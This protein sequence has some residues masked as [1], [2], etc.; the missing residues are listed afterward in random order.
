ML[1]RTSDG[2]R[3]DRPGEGWWIRAGSRAGLVVVVVVVIVVVHGHDRI[4][5]S[6]K[7]CVYGET[8][9]A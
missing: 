1:Q 4:P 8:K 3:W 6:L 2:A 7:V 9:E 5:R